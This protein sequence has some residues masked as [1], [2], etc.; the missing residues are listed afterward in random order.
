MW[1]SRWEERERSM[2][3]QTTLTGP[4]ARSCEKRL[5]SKLELQ[6]QHGFEAIG[7]T[8]SPTRI[9]SVTQS[10]YPFQDR[11]GPAF[12]VRS[13]SRMLAELG[14]R[15]TVLTADLGF[16][17]PTIT[18]AEVVRCAQGWRSEVEGVEVIY[19]TM[20]SR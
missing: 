10:Y 12:K 9:L 3:E 8:G 5:Q 16:A 4:F 2:S 11:G 19:L 7:A 18:S 1:Q 13:I 20:R 15:V 6:P 14:N 17:H